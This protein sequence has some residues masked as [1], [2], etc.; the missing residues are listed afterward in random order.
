MSSTLET[1]GR[2]PSPVEIATT[3]GTEPLAGEPQGPFVNLRR[4]LSLVWHASPRWTIAAVALI[5]VQTALP[6]ALLYVIRR[7]VDATSAAVASNGDFGSV[8]PYLLLAAGIALAQAAVSSAAGLVQDVHAHVV[9]DHMYG[10]LAAQAVRVDLAYYDDPRYRELLRR[11]QRDA[12]NRPG[13]VLNGLLDLVRNGVLFLAMTALL[14]SYHWAMLVLLLVTCAPG[15]IVRLRFARRFFRLDLAQHQQQREAGYVDS[16]LMGIPFAQELRLLSVGDFLRARE[17]RIRHGMRRQRLPLSAKRSIAEFGTDTFALAGLFGAIAFLAN[18]TVVGAIT[19]GGLVMYLQALQRAW[20]GFGATLRGAAGLHEQ[21]LF[22]DDVH[23]FLDLKPTLEGPERPVAV[24][25]ALSNGIELRGVTFRYPEGDREVLRDVTL[26]IGAGE[27]VAIVGR[28]GS[29]KTTLVKL[30]C[31]LYDP[32]AGQITLDGIDLREFE[33]A[34]LRGR[35]TVVVQGSAHYHDTARENIRLGALDVEPDE[36]AIREAARRAGAD[37]LIQQLP[38]GYDTM[39]GRTFEKGHE[40]SAGQ[41]Q[42]LAVARAFVRDAPI[43]ILDEPTTSLDASAAHDFVE[44]FRALSADRTTILVSH[45]L[46]AVMDADRIYVLDE[47]RLA[48][49]GS[50][51]ELLA[52]GGVYARLFRLQRDTSAY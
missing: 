44:R 39:L 13:R 36:H 15:G 27:H 14:V 22:L 12:P 49:T 40:L 20:G 10:L 23:R 7:F 45:R 28:N 16:L 1:R 42:R 4:A 5:T 17:R 46:A 24:P 9:T 32:V 51:D 38:Q 41:W 52:A 3:E 11:A 26:R 35:L 34:E 29:G 43:V 47:G 31:R 8:L 30:L 37:D 33:P 48:E 6:L 21:S 2:S 50:H 19:L 18:E 25:E